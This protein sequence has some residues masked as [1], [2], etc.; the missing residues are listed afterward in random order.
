M[1]NKRKLNLN[2]NE[3]IIGGELSSVEWGIESRLPMSLPKML[4]IVYVNNV[5]HRQY[6]LQCWTL[7]PGPWTSRDIPPKPC[8]QPFVL[9]LL[10]KSN[11]ACDSMNMYLIAVC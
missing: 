2:E 11:I 6:C 4:S 1:Q 5:Q 8:P 3:P 7:N 10:M 9:L